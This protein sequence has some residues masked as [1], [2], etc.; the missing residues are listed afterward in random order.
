V[1]AAIT[2][3]WKPQDLDGLYGKSPLGFWL[4]LRIRPAAMGHGGGHGG[5]R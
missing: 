3:N 2:Y 1:G 5:T 4:F